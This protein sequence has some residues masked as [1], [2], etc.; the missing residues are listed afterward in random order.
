MSHQNTGKCQACEGIFNKYPGFYEPLKEWFFYTQS[1]FPRF[2][3]SCAGRGKIDQEACFSRGASKA[4]W[5]KSSHNFNCAI[6][7]FFLVNGAYCLDESLYAAVVADLDPNIEWY[8]SKDAVFPERPHFEWL[9]W[10]QLVADGI[11]SPVE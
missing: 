11:I 9:S 4:H 10:P 6:D 2:H 7:T 5:L 1:V 8:G 3:V